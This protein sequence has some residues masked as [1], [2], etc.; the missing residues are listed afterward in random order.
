MIRYVYANYGG[1]GNEYHF[2]HAA[3]YLPEHRHKRGEGHTT[4]CLKG[5]AMLIVGDFKLEYFPEDG[6][7]A[8]D[9]TE[10][11]T[12]VA[13]AD[14]TVVF[15]RLESTPPNWRELLGTGDWVEQSAV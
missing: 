5:K 13:L 6:E 7:I 4:K 15:H 3:E 11:H 2:Q 8:F 9:S 14:N 10:P 1:F 12:I